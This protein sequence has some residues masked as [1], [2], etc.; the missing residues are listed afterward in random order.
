MADNNDLLREQVDLTRQLVSAMQDV[1]FTLGKVAEKMGVAADET[2][3]LSNDTDEIEKSLNKIVGLS[4]QYNDELRDNYIVSKNIVDKLE[5][6]MHAYVALNG[7]LENLNAEQAERVTRLEHIIGA[8]RKL[9]ELGEDEIDNRRKILDLLGNASQE[10]DSFI[11]KYIPMGRALSKIIGLNKIKSNLQEGHNAAMDAFNETLATG[12]DITKASSQAMKKFMKVVKLG[13]LLALAIVAALVQ[14]VKL[15]ATLEKQFAEMAKNIGTTVAQA[16]ALSIESQN[17][18]ESLDNQLISM[19]DVLTVQQATIK[20]FGNMSMLSAEVAAEVANIGEAFGYGAEQAAAVNNALIGLGVPAADAAD[21][22]RELATEAAQAGLNVGA[23]T[24]DIAQNAK[25]TAKFFG[26]NVKAL[27]K[28]AFEAGKLGVS[29]DQMAKTAESLLDIE[30]SLANQFEFMALTGKEINFDE[31]RRLA[32][33]N[34][35]A[36]ATKLILDGMGG[37]DEFS[38]MDLFQKEAAAK[39]AGMSVE[40]LSKSLAIQDKLTNATKGQLLAAKGL[41]LSTEQ[42]ANMTPEQ[43]EQALAQEQAA[44]RM[45]ADFADMGNQIKL[46]LLPAGKSFLKIISALTPIF[47]IISGLVE[48]IAFGIEQSALALEIAFRP[49]TTAIEGWEK[50]LSGDLIGAVKLFAKSVLEQLLFPFQIVYENAINAYKRIM[51]LFGGNTD[52]PVYDLAEEA[53]TVTGIND[54]VI[55]PSGNIISTA[56]GD[57]LLATQDPGGLASDVRGGSGNGSMERVEG[58]LQQLINAVSGRPVQVIVGDRVVDE[59]R[60]QADINSTYLVGAR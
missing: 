21:A 45:S 12:G 40:E 46:A 4:N 54:G 25:A 3:R 32:A 37:I 34:D 59:I 23:V 51:G 16:E 27:T 36:G 55:D 43:L 17:V 15:A 7:G 9:Q 30:S 57:Y 44:K 31:A 8:Q 18:A 38:K 53:M 52:I 42:L 39:A 35:I 33:N 20:E 49:I 29:L 56:P 28:A 13:P 47:K 19:K 11:D 58:L 14:L 24:A 2:E 26:G 60:A 1:A 50:L 48:L 41:N 5:E 22:Q 6:E 10:L